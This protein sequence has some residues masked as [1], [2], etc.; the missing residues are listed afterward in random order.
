VMRWLG[1]SVVMGVAAVVCG[2]Q[3][4]MGSSGALGQRMNWQSNSAFHRSATIPDKPLAEMNR[5]E[6][7]QTARAI[8]WINEINRGRTSTYPHRWSQEPKL[9]IWIKCR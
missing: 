2:C 6:L 7:E 9:R 3:S 8:N 5:E 1:W 4:D